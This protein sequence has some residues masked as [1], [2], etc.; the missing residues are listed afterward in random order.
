MAKTLS[1]GCS[2]PLT[3]PFIFLEELLNHFQCCK[4]RKEQSNG[5]KIDQSISFHPKHCKIYCSRLI[6]ASAGELGGTAPSQHHVPA[7]GC[8]PVPGQCG[9]SKSLPSLRSC[10][11]YLPAQPQQAASSLLPFACLL[12]SPRP[13]HQVTKVSSGTFWSSL[14]PALL[15]TVPFELI[16]T[17]HTTTNSPEQRKRAVAAA[18]SCLGAIFSPENEFKWLIFA[19]HFSFNLLLC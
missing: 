9:T 8:C 1:A 11:T 3:M 17:A 5:L 2:A 10:S 4:P 16:I 19:L 15:Q 14:Y 7:G 18:F 6:A 13:Q 12:S